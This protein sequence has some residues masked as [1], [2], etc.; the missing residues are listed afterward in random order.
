MAEQCDVIV[1]PRAVLRVTSRGSDKGERDGNG[2]D[3]KVR[4]KDWHIP[5]GFLK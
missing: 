4:S 5:R 2:E 3:A 1:D